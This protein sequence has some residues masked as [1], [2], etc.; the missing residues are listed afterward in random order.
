MTT[1]NLHIERLVLDGLPSG[2]HEG[3][4]VEAAVK[5]ELSRLIGGADVAAIF[6]ADQ[7]APLIRA[8]ITARPAGAGEPLGT[9]IGRA[10][11]GGIKG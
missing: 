5:A 2:S 4:V 7:A 3:A 11:Y 1:V 8:E 10:L 6:P 9:Q